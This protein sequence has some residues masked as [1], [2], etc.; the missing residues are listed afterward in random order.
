MKISKS[1]LFHMSQ[2]QRISNHKMSPR[3]TSPREACSV[4]F[5]DP[6]GQIK[7]RLNLI[8][9]DSLCLANNVPRVN[10]PRFLDEDNGNDDDSESLSGDIEE[11]SGWFKTYVQESK[12]SKPS[13]KRRSSVKE[14]AVKRRSSIQKF[15]VPT[16]ET[17]K[18]TKRSSI[19][20]NRINRLF[21]SKNRRKETNKKE[22]QASRGVDSLRLHRERLQRCKI[23]A[24][25]KAIK[26]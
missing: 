5:Q 3:K 7:Q 12:A 8:E 13:T 21:F 17:S 10:L 15:T 25:S 4:E 24:A 1:S 19:E 22:F 9:R 20:G 26:K 6:E 23:T 2:M 18:A 16:K 11:D 14:Q